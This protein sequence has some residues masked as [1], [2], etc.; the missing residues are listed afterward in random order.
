[1]PVILKQ[2]SSG[3]LLSFSALQFNILP[4][5]FYFFE[6]EFFFLIVNVSFEFVNLIWNFILPNCLIYFN[7]EF[8]FWNFG[9]QHYSFRKYTLTKCLVLQ[10]VQWK[11]KFVYFSCWSPNQ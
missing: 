2:R 1:M 3:Q 8:C 4:L 6:T 9:D 10:S 11:Y 5:L 7:F